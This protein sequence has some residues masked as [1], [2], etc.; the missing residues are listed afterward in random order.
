MPI[1][2]SLIIGKIVTILFG[3]AAV[4]AVIK[5]G[6]VAA[7]KALIVH[8]AVQVIGHV[9]DALDTANTVSATASFADA[10][11]A[12]TAGSVIT[13]ADD[14]GGGGVGD[15][16]GEGGGWRRKPTYD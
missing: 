7:G 14:V 10:G 15:L 9:A 13:S 8:D 3:K 11:D 2:E 5:T 12:A 1:L 6:A 16:G 4:G